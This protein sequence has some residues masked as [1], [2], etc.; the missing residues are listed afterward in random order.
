MGQRKAEGSGARRGSKGREGREER[1][2]GK[3]GVGQA[4]ISYA[5]RGEL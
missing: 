3:G 4:S 2:R 1:A 5:E